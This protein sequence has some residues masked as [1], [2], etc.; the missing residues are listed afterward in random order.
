[1]KCMFLSLNCGILKE[2]IPRNQIIG[3]VPTAGNVYEDNSFVLDDRKRLH[4][5]GYKVIDMDIDTLSTD[6]F[7]ACLKR[8]DALYIAGGN[9]F[10][11][12]QQIRKKKLNNIIRQYILNEQ[13]WYIG[14]SA[15]SAICAN[16]IEPYRDIDDITKAPE[17]N[18]FDGLK[19]VD[20]YPLPH[21]GKEKYLDVY[22][23]VLRMYNDTCRIVPFR[24]CEAIIPQ[25]RD[26]YR[27]E[28]SEEIL[29]K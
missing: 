22:F 28:L 11:L 16:S 20:F 9:T 24:N 14:A 13:G 6:D 18:T 7:S 12:M 19:I 21:F 29:I 2:Y 23:G 27:M 25:S 4:I 5:M 26:I 1:M 17:L 15:G 10:Y 8:I 3:F